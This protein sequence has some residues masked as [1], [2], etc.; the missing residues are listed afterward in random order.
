MNI[1]ADLEV[2]PF[3]DLGT[4]FPNLRG[5][6]RQ[7]VRAV[8]GLGLRAA[9]KPNVVGDLEVGVG[10]EGPAIFVDLNYPF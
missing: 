1:E 9:F 6:Q 3:V 8:G 7:Y 2:A 4:V 5:I 10:N